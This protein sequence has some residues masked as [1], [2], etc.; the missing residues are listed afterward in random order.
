MYVC[1][2]AFSLTVTFLCP[3]PLSVRADVF[4]LLFPNTFTFS[5]LFALAQIWQILHIRSNLL[6]VRF[7]KVKLRGR[8]TDL[9]SSY[10]YQIPFTA[11]L[12]AVGY[13][14]HCF[15]SITVPHCMDTVILHKLSHVT[16][17]IGH[18]IVNC[19]SC[20]PHNTE[21]ADRKRGIKR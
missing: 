16:L 5:K 10:T 14:L 7:L 6:A 17:C 9:N 21:N 8:R 3:F 20:G 11:C 13:F 2:S 12:L 15:V 18:A 4:N 1:S 19:P